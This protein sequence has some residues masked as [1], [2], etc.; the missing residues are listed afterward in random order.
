MTFKQNWEKAHTQN[1]L[2]PGIIENMLKLACP[3][4]NLISYEIISGGCA[5]INVKVNFEQSQKI[6]RIYLR[7]KSAA[8]RESKLGYLLKDKL[9][10]PQVK[11]VGEHEGFCFS[12][13]T[14]I[15]GI[16][17]RELLL[18][19]NT[20]SLKEIM[21]ELGILL[22][23]IASCQFPQAGFFDENLKVIKSISRDNLVTFARE[24][25]KNEVVLSMLGKDLVSKIGF[26]LNRHY[27]L[28][29]GSDSHNLVHADYDPANILV[30][31]QNNK[32]EITGIIDWE[33]SFSGS[34]LCDVANMLR[35]AHEMPLEY[36]KGFLE[37][38]RKGG[39][40]LPSNW[41]TSIYMLNILSLLDCLVRSDPKQ[42]PNQCADILSLITHIINQLEEQK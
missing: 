23:K 34:V 25:L 11:Y 28:L 10:V 8:Q 31:K 37:G 36:E 19:E 35:Y 22:S 14:L 18:S 6:L 33:F 21:Y 27:E 20:Y 42:R 9:S 29:P 32:W 16:T 30:E 3:D 26:Y 2:P 15:P 38:L 12:L 7:D 17:L 39:I 4:L 13:M 5:N 40:M 24:C 1:K 41:R